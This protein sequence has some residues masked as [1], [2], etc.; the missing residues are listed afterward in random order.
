MLQANQHEKELSAIKER[1][2]MLDDHQ[3]AQLH[4]L[5]GVS[6]I[7]TTKYGAD[8]PRRLRSGASSPGNSRKYRG[9][10]DSG[11]EGADILSDDGLD[12]EPVQEIKCS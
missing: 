2:D 4:E 9:G 11:S 12:T 1:L 10:A 5:K 8:S 7:V 3:R 6:P